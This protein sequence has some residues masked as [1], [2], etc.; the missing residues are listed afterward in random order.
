MP[1]LEGEPAFFSAM[2]AIQERA[3]SG[4]PPVAQT[5]HWKLKPNALKSWKLQTPALTVPKLGPDPP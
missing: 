1:L 5:S 4:R 2:Y 3:S